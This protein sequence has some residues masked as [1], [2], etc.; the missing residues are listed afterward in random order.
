MNIE[1]AFKNIRSNYRGRFVKDNFLSSPKLIDSGDDWEDYELYNRSESFFNIHRVEFDT[2]VEINLEG[3]AL[4]MNLVEGR[5]IEIEDNNGR[6]TTLALYE[7]ILVP[8]ATKRLRIK[9]I[10]KY[11]SKLLYA[12]IRPSAITGRLND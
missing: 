6:V 12:Y 9:N 7:T 5:K 3:R 1:R 2:E 8:E 10:S 11:R 4:T